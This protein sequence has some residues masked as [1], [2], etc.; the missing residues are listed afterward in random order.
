[1]FF[2]VGKR[3]ADG[4]WRVV[5]RKSL[6]SLADIDVLV[7]A[8]FRNFNEHIYGEDR[9]MDEDARAQSMCVEE[10]SYTAMGFIDSV[11]HKSVCVWC[12]CVCV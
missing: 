4:G 5:A 10:I 6:E 3:G 11:Q 9:G 2:G 12:K 7:F 1:M 8:G